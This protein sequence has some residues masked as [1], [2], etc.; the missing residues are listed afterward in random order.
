[1]DGLTHPMGLRITSTRRTRWWAP[2]R[3]GSMSGLGSPT[4]EGGPLHP[5][6]TPCLPPSVLTRL[7]GGSEG[8][9]TRAAS[10]AASGRAAAAVLA[11]RRVGTRLPG[12]EGSGAHAASSAAS[13]RAAAAVLA[14]R[15]VGTRL[16]GSGGSGT[17]AATSAASGRAA[18]AVL[19]R[20]RV[21]ARFPGLRLARWRPGPAQR[22]SGLGGFESFGLAA[23]CV[24][25]RRHACAGLCGDAIRGWVPPRCGDRV[26]GG[27][28][29][30][31]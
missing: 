2:G 1:M 3:G 19:A 7:H 18:A 13:R 21:C 16:P 30:G 6:G 24:R 4:L 9:E 12:L 15:R 26:A 25:L 31:R 23:D 11:R 22:L 20:R 17:R 29:R 5:P 10:P 8:S 27:F 14:R 28:G